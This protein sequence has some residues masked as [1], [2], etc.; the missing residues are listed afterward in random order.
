MADE[1][2]TD[3]TEEEGSAAPEKGKK[4]PKAPKASKAPKE[5]ADGADAKEPK[6]KKGKKEKTPKVKGEKSGAG[7]IIFIMVLILII[8]IGGF[9]A[10]LYFDVFDSRTII[11]EVVTEPLLEVVIWLDPS[12]NTIRQRLRAEEEAS[13]KRFADR[14]DEL[15]R[16]EEEV[17]MLENA[18]GT[19]ELFVERRIH[20]LDRREEQILAMYER[21]MPLWRRDMTEEELADMESISR[22]YTNMSPEDAAN[23]LVQLYDPRDVAAILYFMGERN[24]AAILSQMDVRYAANITEILLY[25]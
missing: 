2:V 14:M 1:E 15:A 22:I 24:S 7:G 12:Y 4:A 16:R 19:R 18:V 3:L 11:A 6:D 20:D 17:E 25:S 10:A 5:P 9:G 21:T 13:I 8:L 23:R